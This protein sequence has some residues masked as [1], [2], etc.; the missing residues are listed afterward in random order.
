MSMKEGG[1]KHQPRTL[2]SDEEMRLLAGF[3]VQPFLAAGVAFMIFPWLLLDRAGRTL[4]GGSPADP[5]AAAVSVA[6]ATG[7]AACL[8]TLFGVSRPLYGY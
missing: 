4:A 1:V 5:T 7:I 2:T 6:L 8:V 3:V